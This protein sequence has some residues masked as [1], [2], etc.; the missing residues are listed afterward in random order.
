M[1]RTSSTSGRTPTLTKPMLFGEMNE[2]VELIPRKAC[3]MREQTSLASWPRILVPHKLESS[4]DVS[5]YNPQRVLQ[6]LV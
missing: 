5:I 2:D 6:Q 1:R 3:S 4:E